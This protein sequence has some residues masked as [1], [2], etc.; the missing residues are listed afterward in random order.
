M[1][2]SLFPQKQERETELES[3][4]T[5]AKSKR[6]ASIN[7]NDHEAQLENLLAMWFRLNSVSFYT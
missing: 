3:S 4:D 6:A 1:W 7:Q 5:D 2:F